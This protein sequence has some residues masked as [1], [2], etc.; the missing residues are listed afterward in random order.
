MIVK[1]IQLE[2]KEDN[3]SLESVI[4]LYEGLGYEEVKE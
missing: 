1:N 3:Y 4:Q 2:E